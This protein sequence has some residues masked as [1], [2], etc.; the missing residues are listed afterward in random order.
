MTPH[1]PQQEFE[2]PKK[3]QLYLVRESVSQTGTPEAILTQHYRG[4]ATPHED[5]PRADM[6]RPGRAGQGRRRRA[7]LIYVSL[8]LIFI[9]I[10]A[11][12]L[13]DRGVYAIFILTYARVRDVH[14]AANA[15]LLVFI[16]LGGIGGCA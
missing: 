4:A 6:P 1:I 14:P 8:L 2:K 12:P 9:C 3:H 7:A 10:Y 13:S 11:C 16:E 15:G 5:G